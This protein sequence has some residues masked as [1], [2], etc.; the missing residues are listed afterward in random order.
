MNDYPF[1]SQPLSSSAA[2]PSP[3]PA[4][5]LPDKPAPDS[6]RTV[7][8]WWHLSQVIWRLA[9][10][11]RWT[12]LKADDVRRLEAILELLEGEVHLARTEAEKAR[13]TE[14]SR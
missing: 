9:R 4:S 10:S 5:S 3:R 1:P 2:P 11:I 7:M 12:T 8:L 14:K 13:A 6:N